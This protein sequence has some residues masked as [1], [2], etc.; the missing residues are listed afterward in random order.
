MFNNDLAFLLFPQIV[1]DSYMYFCF[2]VEQILSSEAGGQILI[3]FARWF[4]NKQLIFTQT[5]YGYTGHHSQN[6]SG[7]FHSILPIK[8][9]KSDI[10]LL[11]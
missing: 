8:W 3:T 7:C 1:L 5:E 10:A 2:P 6:C 4:T 9:V 11:L